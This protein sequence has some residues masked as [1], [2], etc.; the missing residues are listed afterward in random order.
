MKR[1]RLA[2]LKMHP[3]VKPVALVADAIKDCSNRGDIVLDAFGGSGTTIIAAEETGRRG[4]AIELAPE[5]VDVAVRRWQE[6]TGETAVEAI[7]EF[8]FAEAEQWVGRADQTR[9]PAKEAL[10]VG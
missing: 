5:Y 7:T 4:Y 2:E 9:V 10:G 8:T 1:G 3:T 6:Y